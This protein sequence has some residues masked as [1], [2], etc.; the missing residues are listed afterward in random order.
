MDNGLIKEQIR[1][2]GIRGFGEN[3]HRKHSSGLFPCQR[4][5]RLLEKKR[6]IK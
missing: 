2:N 3:V 5:D 4:G 1:E 6:E